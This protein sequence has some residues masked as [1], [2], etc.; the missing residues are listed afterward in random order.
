MDMPI[1]KKRLV[2]QLEPLCFIIMIIRS[3]CHVVVILQ[4]CQMF[5]VEHVYNNHFKF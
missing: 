1:N 2:S 3:M 4:L 5:K